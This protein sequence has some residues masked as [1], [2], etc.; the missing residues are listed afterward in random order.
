MAKNYY[1]NQ[2]IYLRP[3]LASI[4]LFLFYTIILTLITAIL[5]LHDAIQPFFLSLLLSHQLPQKLPK[6]TLDYFMQAFFFHIITYAC[7]LFIEKNIK[8]NNQNKLNKDTWRGVSTLCDKTHKPKKIK[9][10]EP[11]QFAHKKI[12]HHLLI[13]QIESILKQHKNHYAGAGHGVGIYQHSINVYKNA[14]K[15]PHRDPLLPVCSIM[16]DLGK[17]TSYGAKN[18]V[19]KNHANESISI[20][21]PFDKFS[22]LSNEDKN[23]ITL[24]VRYHHSKTVPILNG[25]N[26]EKL[27][28]LRQQL[29]SCDQKA[30][31]NEKERFVEEN[32]DLQKIVQSFWNK[33]KNHLLLQQPGMRKN[34]KTNGWKRGQYIYL[35]EQT[36]REEGLNELSIDEMSALGKREQGKLHLFTIELM[37]FLN[38][39]NNLV[40]RVK[41]VKANKNG[42]FRIKSGKNIYNGIIIITD[43]NIKEYEDTSYDITVI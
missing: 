43:N 5:S 20:I 16:H 13:N 12:K 40:T 18:E 9:S 34:K 2:K 38:T 22:N 19:L 25:V 7:Y 42:L 8:K 32:I 31:V 11:S 35:I 21:T 1:D 6:E 10:K 29:K 14:L 4:P 37:K 39:Q 17:I 3:L 27:S 28:T 33:K 23:L 24:V 30:T 36:I 15:M 26:L 41:N